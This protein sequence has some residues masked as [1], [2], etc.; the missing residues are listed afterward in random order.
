MSFLSSADHVNPFGKARN[1]EII[2]GCPSGS[3]KEYSNGLVVASKTPV[4]EV[5]AVVGERWQTFTNAHWT[6]RN[7]PGLQCFR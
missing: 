5:L 7:L 3:G 2:F 1:D 6:D 4:C